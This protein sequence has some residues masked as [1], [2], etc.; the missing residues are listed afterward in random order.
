MS[1]NKEEIYHQIPHYIF[2]L[3][4][5]Y[6]TS[7][8]RLLLLLCNHKHIFRKVIHEINKNDIYQLPYL[9]KCIME[10]LRLMNPLITT[11]RTL[12]QDY[13]FYRYNNN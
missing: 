7:I 13:T 10:T 11:F 5:L 8:P 12:L 1:D 9:R 2:P 3:A 4:G 6:V